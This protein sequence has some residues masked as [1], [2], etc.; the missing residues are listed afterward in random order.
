MSAQPFPVKTPRRQD[1]QH[2]AIGSRSPPRPVAWNTARF[3]N[4]PRFLLQAP[5]QR[6]QRLNTVSPQRAGPRNARAVSGST[7]YAYIA[8]NGEQTWSYPAAG[9]GT[10][11]APPVY[12]R[13]SIYLTTSSGELIT[14]V[15]SNGA[16][17]WED[18]T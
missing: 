12:D 5:V 8:S 18:T 9:F 3:A 15:A 13:T 14:L 1:A 2:R 10:I 16:L 7:L 11:T 6:P 4:R 17:R